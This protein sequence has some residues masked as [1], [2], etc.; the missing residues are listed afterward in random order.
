[1]FKYEILVSLSRFDNWHSPWMRRRKSQVSWSRTRALFFCNR[2]EDWVNIGLASR[3]VTCPLRSV[4]YHI[5]YLQIFKWYF[6]R[7]SIFNY[8]KYHLLYLHFSP[9]I[10]NHMR[11][12]FCPHSDLQPNERERA[13]PR[14]PAHRRALCRWH[15]R[16]RNQV[17]H[18][19][20]G[21]PSV[22]DGEWKESAIEPDPIWQDQRA[23]A[24]QV[25]I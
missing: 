17:G 15:V 3:S 11:Y 22:G 7:V 19:I 18:W 1:M 23:V 2:K 13:R 8:T 14:T 5:R 9:A 12:S 16:K 25:R 10:H 21:R 20:L 24:Y 4:C 6:Q